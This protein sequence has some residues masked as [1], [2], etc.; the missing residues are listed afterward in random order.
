M[1][2]A[3]GSSTVHCAGC[4]DPAPGLHRPPPPQLNG[5]PIP[6]SLLRPPSLLLSNGSKERKMCYGAKETPVDCA[7]WVGLL[8][9]KRLLTQHHMTGIVKKAGRRMGG[10]FKLDS[11]PPAHHVAALEGSKHRVYVCNN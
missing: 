8:R 9:N 4:E 10:T 2:K 7:Q 5:R 11:D 1:I 3:L 6:K